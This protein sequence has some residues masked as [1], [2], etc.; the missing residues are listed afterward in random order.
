LT[1]QI[2]IFNYHNVKGFLDVQLPHPPVEAHIF[3]FDIVIIEN[4]E[5]C[6]YL[7][8]PCIRK[9][10]MNLTNIIGCFNS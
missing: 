2:F 3:Y 8:W 1:K 6:P 4:T 10:A 7:L 9:K 5:N